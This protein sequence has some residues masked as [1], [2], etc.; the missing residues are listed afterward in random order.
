MTGG[1]PSPRKLR[2]QQFGGVPF[3]VKSPLGALE[4]VVLDS[5]GSAGGPFV[6]RAL[7]IRRVV[8]LEEFFARIPAVAGPAGGQSLRPQL[9]LLCL[10]TK[11]NSPRCRLREENLA[12]ALLYRIRWRYSGASE[13]GGGFTCSIINGFVKTSQSSLKSALRLRGDPSGEINLGPGPLGQQPPPPRN[14]AN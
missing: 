2:V 11:L 8:P 5:P 9:G 1:I 7:P 13:G 4:M 12:A 3:C 6:S 10:K 14:R